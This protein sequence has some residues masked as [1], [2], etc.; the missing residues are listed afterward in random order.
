MTEQEL[1]ITKK[2]ATRE[3]GKILKKVAHLQK[4][5][6]SE[7]LLSTVE[8]LLNVAIPLVSISGD[9]TLTS[10]LAA[11]RVWIDQKRLEQQEEDRRR[12]AIQEQT[13]D[14]LSPT[15]GW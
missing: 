11:L 5:A 6:I 14:S 12:Q 3:A 1:L 7:G 13:W 10:L 15:Y 9:M 4:K 2:V 8:M